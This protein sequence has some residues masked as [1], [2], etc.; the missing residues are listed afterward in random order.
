MIDAAGVPT[1]RLRVYATQP[2]Q[3][4]EILREI[5]RE[6]YADVVALGTG[7]TQQ[8]LTDQFRAFGIEG[9]TVRKAI[10]FYLN[11]ARQ[12]EIPLSPRFKT[13]RPGAGGRKSTARR[14]KGKS[15]DD[16][17]NPLPPPPP[18]GLGLHPAILT[19]VQA[20]PEFDANSGKPRFSGAD[21]KAWFD[22]AEATFNLIYA[23]PIEVEA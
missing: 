20:L 4:S 22:Y 6:H 15:D 23:L 3:R 8:Q 19:L 21:R 17:Q 2:E 10:A 5:L 9:E 7:A 16:E 1:D 14:S 18:G 13:T 11:A 12:A